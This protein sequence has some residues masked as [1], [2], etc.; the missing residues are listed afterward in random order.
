MVLP[1]KCCPECIKVTPTTELPTSTE[2]GRLALKLMSFIR[3]HQITLP[4]SFEYFF[5][6]CVR[7]VLCECMESCDDSDF[8]DVTPPCCD[9]YHCSDGYVRNKQN[10]CV[11]PAVCSEY[12][13]IY[14]Y[15]YIQW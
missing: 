2:T 9:D 6:E 11:K 8:C 5:T 7:N 14:S 13:F 12:I 4:A 1:G 3:H 10:V 15:I